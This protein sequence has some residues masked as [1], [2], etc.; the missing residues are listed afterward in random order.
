MID[1]KIKV[2]IV[3]D[4]PTAR[5][6]VRLLLERDPEVLVIGEASSG[7]EAVR[8]IVEDKPDLIFLDVQM[9]EMMNRN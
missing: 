5:R 4:E 8:K 9:P 6:G 1:T 2:L 3:D 7:S